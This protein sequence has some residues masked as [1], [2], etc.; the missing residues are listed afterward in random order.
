MRGLGLLRNYLAIFPHIN[1]RMVVRAVAL[2]TLA[3]RR[4]ARPTSCAKDFASAVPFAFFMAPPPAAAEYRRHY[5]RRRASNEGWFI[6]SISSIWF[7]WLVGPEIHP[8]EPD[9]PANQTD[10]PVARSASK[11]GTWP[12][13]PPSFQACSFP[14]PPPNIPIIFFAGGTHRG[15]RRGVRT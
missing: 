11:K 13:P 2:A 9:R 15:C 5:R 1:R 4:N 12:L 7:V 8:E 3:A 6:W 10:K 14:S